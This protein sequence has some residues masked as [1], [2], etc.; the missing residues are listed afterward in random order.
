MRLLVMSWRDS[1]RL[2]VRVTRGVLGQTWWLSARLSRE[3]EHIETKTSKPGSKDQLDS[4]R[5][6]VA[7]R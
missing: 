7:R 5:L 4:G 1:L 2:L 6:F 3:G